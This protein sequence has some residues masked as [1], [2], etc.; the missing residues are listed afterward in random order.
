MNYLPRKVSATNPPSK[1]NMKEVPRK[2]VTVLAELALP[3][4]I[5]S[6]KYVTKLTAMPRVVNLSH[7]STPDHHEPATNCLIK[8]YTVVT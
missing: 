3:K 8:I 6:V 1:H 4:C 5:V 2:L 7:A